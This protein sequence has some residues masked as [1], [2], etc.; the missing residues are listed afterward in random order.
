[1]PKILFIEDESALQKM[2]KDALKK[3][4]KGFEVISALNGEEGLQLA[5][6]EKP[7][8]ILLDIILPKMN[9]FEVLREIKKD[10]HLKNIPLI[11]LT[12][13]DSLQDVEKAMNLG[14]YQYLVKSEQTIKDI[15]EKIE[16]T[17][18]I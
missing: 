18:K 13:M 17:L 3:E 8:L 6:K 4:E 16:T 1:M 14:V 7:D 2:L 11:I 15:V 12:N 9:G 5:K 10:N